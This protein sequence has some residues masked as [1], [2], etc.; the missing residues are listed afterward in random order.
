MN[1]EHRFPAIVW[2]AIATVSLAVVAV[3]GVPVSC[4]ASDAAQN[5]VPEGVR[6]LYL[7]RH[8]QY[9]H[10]DARDPD[11][12]KA[13]VPLGIAQA[14]LV[15]ARLRSLPVE[16]TSLRSS[17]MTRARQ[18]ALVIGESFPGL[19]L[20]QSTLLRECTPPTWRKDAVSDVDP[21]EMT[22]CVDQ[23]EKA[24]TE[25]FVPSPDFERHDIVVC[26]GNV[27]RY[28]VTKAL[29][30]DTMAWLGMSIGNCSVTV[31]RVD[32]NGRMK[33][34]MFGDVGHIPPNLQTGLGGAEN[35]L[36]V[37]GGQYGSPKER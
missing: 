3:S 30:V 27:I 9:D 23:L 6:Y 37:P 29:G 18:T 5:A 31:I 17:T 22:E 13:L 36:V 34:L 4:R 20:E 25:F 1:R 26:H 35:S 24:Y 2:L 32:P 19:E 8:G 33:L 21:V 10:E 7:I 28:F 11:V 14:R 15:A 16:M 12:G